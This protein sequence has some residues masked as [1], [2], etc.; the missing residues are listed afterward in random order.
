MCS[1]SGVP[2]QNEQP[3]ATQIYSMWKIRFD[4]L[5]PNKFT[6]KDKQDFKIFEKAKIEF[7]KGKQIADLAKLVFSDSIRFFSCLDKML[8]QAKEPVNKE[9][10]KEWNIGGENYELA[11]IEVVSNLFNPGFPNFSLFVR[12]I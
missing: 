7:E 2:I 9:Q 12:K 6:A 5:S 8:N 3:E 10:I 4:T 11:S 1:K